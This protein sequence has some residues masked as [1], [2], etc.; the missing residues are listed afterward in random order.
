M[1]DINISNL[2]VITQATGDDMIIIND[3]NSITSII[4]WDRLTASISKLSGQISFDAGSE[5]LPSIIFDNDVNSGF[6]Q[7]DSD[8]LGISTGGVARIFIDSNGS[9][10]INNTNPGDFN[11][12]ANN[13]VIGSTTEQD[14]GI[15]LVTSATGENIINFADGTGL[16]A[17]V[18]QLIYDHDNNR[19]TCSTLGTE[20]Y[21][22]TN[23][24][25]IIIGAE[26]D[27][28][29]SRLTVAGGSVTIEDGSDLKPALNFRAD[30][31]TGITRPADDN[32]AVVTGGT[33]RL[34]V[35]ET[36]RLGIGIADPLA[37]IHVNKADATLIVTDSDAAG[38]PE[39][40]VVAADGNL[41]V[42][43]DDN[44]AAADS[45]MSL[46]VDGSELVRLVDSGEVIVP[47]K[48][49]FNEAADDVT[50]PYARVGLGIDGE[51]LL[52]ADPSNLY[53]DSGV[54]INID[55]SDAFFLSADGDVNI[56]ANGKIYWGTDTNTWIDHPQE[57]TIEIVTGGNEAVVA[58]PDGSVRFGTLGKIDQT[59]QDFLFG[60]TTAYV[61]GGHNHSFQLSGNAGNYGTH[62]A[63]FGPGAGGQHITFLKSAGDGT[64]PSI[65]SD[66][67]ELGSLRFA[68]DNGLDYHSIGAT[69]SAKVD[70]VVSATSTPA[71]LIIS[72][73]PANSVAPTE[74]V[75]ISHSGA[76]GLGGENYGGVGQ[77]IISN[78]TGA[79]PTWQDLPLYDISTLPDLP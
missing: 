11:S 67:D 8:K 56:I 55:G 74:R 66:D 50:D 6:Y 28:E 36:G 59:G 47:N 13:L 48:V 18:A 42:R 71:S 16:N 12:G 65:V 7:P 63:M 60:S 25:D 45:R 19:M 14:T 57:D 5:T 77:L 34:V 79:G 17:A 26:T 24:Q 33:Q 53:A 37:D 3:A 30:L 40:K 52:E 54:R 58:E 32:L 51:I 61:V 72:T 62:V 10:G 64:T 9:V 38:T 31:N 70:G 49:V 1:S 75:R 2:P 46:Y 21:R 43:V 20:V 76:I 68:A 35:D 73:T 15:T 23:E 4:N 44:A 78:G 29:D 22:I 39:F 69:V 27:D 41:E